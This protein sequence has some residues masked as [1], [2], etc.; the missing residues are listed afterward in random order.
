MWN[1]IWATGCKDYTR[2]TNVMPQ[3]AGSSWYQLRYIDPENSK[4]LCAKENEAYWMG[5]RPDLHGPT[6]P[7]G[8]DLYVGGVEHA[9]LHLLYSR[10]WHKVLFDLGYVSSAEPYRRLYN[11]GMI[12]AYAFTD[13]RGI[14]V[15]AEEVT[16]EDGKFFYEGNEVNREYGKMGKSLKNSVAPDDICRDY[17]ADTLRVYEM[18]MGPLDTSRA[19]GDQ[20]CRR[21]TAVP[22]ASV[23]AGGRRGE[24]RGPGHR[25]RTDGRHEPVAAQDDRRS[26]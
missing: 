15:P 13:S 21:S 5:P 17:G 14:Y 19:V 10:F 12:Q 22:A 23:A 25:G 6:D 16:E 4:E 24:R 20:G 1:S 9:V 2:D 3:W 11:Q 8:L 7:G 26:A 18:S